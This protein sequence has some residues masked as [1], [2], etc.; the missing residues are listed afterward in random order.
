MAEQM[1]VKRPRRQ[2]QRQAAAATAA[3]V[4]GATPH[5]AASNAG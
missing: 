5:A 2:R 4:T 3:G 1:K